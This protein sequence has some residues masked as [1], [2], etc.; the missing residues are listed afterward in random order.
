MTIVLICGNLNTEMHHIRHVKDLKS[1]P[2][3]IKT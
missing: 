1:K 3:K 2:S